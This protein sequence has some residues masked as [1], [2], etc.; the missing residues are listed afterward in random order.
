MTDNSSRAMVVT[1]AGAVI[2]GVTAYLVLTKRGRELCR[3][4]G[5]ALDDFARELNSFRLTAQKAAGVA[6][7]GWRLVNEA[8][9]QHQ[10]KRYPTVH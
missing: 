1:I 2:G 10:N 5:P 4:I 8:L 7:Q 3:Q 9:D 6:K